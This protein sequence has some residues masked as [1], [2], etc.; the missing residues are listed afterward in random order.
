MGTGKRRPTYPGP[1]IFRTT[2]TLPDGRVV[3]AR[4]YGLRAFPIRLR[5]RQ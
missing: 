4:D 3:H 1:V 2:T 5:K